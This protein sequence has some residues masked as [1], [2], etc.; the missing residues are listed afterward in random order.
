MKIDENILFPEEEEM[1]QYGFI[2]HMESY[3]KQLLQDPLHAKPD[4]YLLKHQIDGPKALAMLLKRVDETNPDSAILKRKERIAPED[5]G[6][7]TDLNAKPKDM[8]HIKYSLPRKDYY[9]KMRNL[10]INTFESHIIDKCPINEDGEGVFVANGAAACNDSAPILPLGKKTTGNTDEDKK[11]DVIKRKTMY[12]TSEQADK[13]RKMLDEDAPAVMNTQAGDFGYDAPGLET[14]SNDP[15]FDHKDMMKKSW[16]GESA[17]GLK[18]KKLFDIFKEYG[19]PKYGQHWDSSE[20][21]DLHNVTDNDVIGVFQSNEIPYNTKELKIWLINK[22][23]NI[24]RFD[25]V[26][27]IQLAKLGNN[28]NLL[29]ALVISRNDLYDCYSD[30]PEGGFKDF[31]NKQNAREKNR[32]GDGAREYQWKDGGE[33]KRMMMQNP[34]YKEWSPESKNALKQKIKDIYK[35]DK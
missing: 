15:T 17:R 25:G 2:S 6:E 28:G 16:V 27:R 4:E 34:Y 26:R 14:D 8:F 5:L 23:Y 21:M 9:K 35:N 3:I 20:G 13:I 30:S 29:Y 22:G 1:T 7:D 31:V 32:I 11:T 33:G 18:S 10:Y 12:I 19:R 24:S